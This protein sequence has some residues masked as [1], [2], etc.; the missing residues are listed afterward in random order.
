MKIIGVDFSINKPAVCVYDHSGY[1]FYSAPFGLTERV[2]DIYREAGVAILERTDEKYK[3]KDSSEKMR[4]E[5]N[6]SIYLADLLTR[7]LP[8][9]KMEDWKVS[10]EG[11]S[12]AS[13]GNVALQLGGYKYVLMEMWFN[14]G[15]AFENMYT[16]APITIKKTA[17][18]SKK[19]MKKKDMIDSFIKNAEGNHLVNALRKDPTQFHKKTGTWIDHLDDFVDAYWAV[20]TYK[21]KNP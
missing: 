19:G 7:G 9:G 3:G 17:G 6:N 16:Y 11:F 5:V 14:E 21:E 10:Y 12:F 18:C 20:E 2:L 13:S 8:T 15:I 1:T 4:W